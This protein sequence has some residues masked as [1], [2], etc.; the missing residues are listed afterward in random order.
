MS[1][2]DV[3]AD[4][5]SGTPGAAWWSADDI[6][7][8][9]VQGEV[10]HYFVRATG[11]TL[12]RYLQGVLGAA[13][14]TARVAYAAGTTLPPLAYTEAWDAATNAALWRFVADA[15]AVPGTA[16]DPLSQTYLDAI[17]RVASERRV[18]PRALAAA[19]WAA[20]YAGPDPRASWAR[21]MGVSP[22]SIALWI[23]RNEG[24]AAAT[25]MPPFGTPPAA[26]AAPNDLQFLLLDPT[27]GAFTV[28]APRALSGAPRAIGWLGVPRR[29]WAVG[30]L[31]AL[32][33]G[34]AV[35]YVRREDLRRAWDD[36]GWGARAEL[37]S[38]TSRRSRG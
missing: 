28:T 24:Q 30:G 8:P 7:G 31:V 10:A 19:I 18:N 15:A 21:N 9:E 6:S 16:P 25:R 35:V 1:F 14:P 11:R 2:T 17:E 26:T 13:R 33:G 23:T 36:R 37:P 3:A 4:W 22:P 29:V 5:T 38:R 20:F 34:L 32:A 12:L 27:T